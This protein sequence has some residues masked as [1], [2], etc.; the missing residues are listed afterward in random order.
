MGRNI[1]LGVLG[2]HRLRVRRGVAGA[3]YHEVVRPNHDHRTRSIPGPFSQH[4]SASFAKGCK[5]CLDTLCF[6]TTATTLFEAI[7]LAAP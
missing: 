5:I 6:S 3:E 4:Y 7:L 2:Y 1:A